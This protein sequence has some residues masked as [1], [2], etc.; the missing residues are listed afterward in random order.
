M[1]FRSNGPI[2]LALPAFRGFTRRLILLAVVTFFAFWLIASFAP[3]SV[4]IWLV[5]HFPLMPER[6]FRGEVWQLL[7]YSLWPLPLLSELFAL[8]SLWFFASPLENERGGRWLL[9]F[10][11]VSVVGG[12]LLSA[13]FVWLGRGHLFGIPAHAQ[14]AGLWPAALAVLLA[15]AHFHAE[16]EI[17]FNLIFR[18]RAKYLVAIYLLIYLASALVG[19]DR[20]GALTV[21]CTALAGW[22]YLRFVPRRGLGFSATE[23]WYGLRNAFYRNKRR[24]A[25][26]EFEVYMR[27]EGRDVHFDGNGK[28]IDEDSR[29]P[30]NPNDRRWMN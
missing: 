2:M 19:N 27:K 26:K 20:F 14:A 12:G 4:T 10:L 29:N 13:L 8:L 23:R 15:Y 25:A 11:A 1:A 21:V 28:L 7:T 18:V 3:A 16:E 5:S 9:E 30:R 24:R 22:L 17:N 6:L